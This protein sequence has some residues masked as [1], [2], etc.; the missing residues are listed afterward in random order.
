MALTLKQEKFCQGIINGLSGKDAYIAAYNTKGNDNTVY[1]EVT[2]LFNRDEIQARLKAL[3]EP[4]ELKA[5]TDAITE[6]ERIKQILWEEIANARAQQDHAAI[7]RYTDQL[8]KLNNAYRDAGSTTDSTND[9][10]TLDLNTLKRI[11]KMA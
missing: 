10:D 8:N 1:T 9:L 3:R 5:Q 4:L 2:R 11:T 7:A 6:T